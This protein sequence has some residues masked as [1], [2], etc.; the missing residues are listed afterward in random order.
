MQTLLRQVVLAENPMGTVDEVKGDLLFLRSGESKLQKLQRK[1]VA[2]S[3]RYLV[4]E[5]GGQHIAAC[6]PK[7]TRPISPIRGE[8]RAF[9]I[10]RKQRRKTSRTGSEPFSSP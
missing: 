9:S 4:L 7:F 6:G 1:R 3:F 8:N 5:N 10:G 2:H